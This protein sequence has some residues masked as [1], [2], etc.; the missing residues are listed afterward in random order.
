MSFVTEEDVISMAEGLISTIWNKAAGKQ[1]KLPFP[2][3]TYHEALDKYG[4]D[5]PDLRFGL[6]LVEVTELAQRSDFKVFVE[7]VKNQGIVKCVNAEK[8][9]FTR[10][11]IEEMTSFA[12]ENGA[13]GLAWMKVTEKGLESNIVKFF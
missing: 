1:L 6:E 13:K 7:T 12:Q 11:Q 2:R 3:M 8:A 9:N 5:R 10:T 4:I